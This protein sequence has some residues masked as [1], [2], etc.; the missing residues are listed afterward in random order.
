MDK[1]Y[2]D[3]FQLSLEKEKFL[4][5]DCFF[6]FDSSALLCFYSLSET[7]RQKIYNEIFTLFKGR[8][9]LPAHVQFEFFKNRETV[10]KKSIPEHYNPIEDSL[11]SIMSDIKNADKKLEELLKKIKNQNYHPF[12]EQTNLE[13][14]RKYL[15]KVP[16]F[17]KKVKTQIEERK[18]EILQLEK[19]DSVLENLSVYFEVGKE[20]SFK[21]IIEIC[22]E[23]DHRY[24]YKIP[25][26]FKDLT[27]KDKEGI[28]IF[29]DL[30][31]WKQIL[32]F[33]STKKTNIVFVCNDFTTDW[34]ITEPDNK[35]R[36]NHPKE[37]LILEFTETTGKNFWMYSL[38]QF[39]YTCNR[40]LEIKTP[41]EI[42]EKVIDQITE[43][44]LITKELVIIEAKYFTPNNSFDSKYKLQ[45]L[46]VNN[47]LDTVA[48][49]S[50]VGDP[51]INSYKKLQIKY[52]Y[53]N[54]IFEKIYNEHDQIHIP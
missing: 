42:K 1:N 19:H 53:G 36:I 15:D 34:C 11:K 22:R 40:L 21:E 45:S 51:E 8:L 31:I 18:N 27:E 41:I 20:Y 23:G 43:D 38:D 3:K 13:S 52:S 49:N 46:I 35:K 17:E 25:P 4:W 33:A 54:E 12:I 6:V 29:G 24:D 32:E 39:I 7:A 50:L 30:I 44:K 10:I 2:F 5:A 48:D 16:D 14:L 26:G 47:K 9:W 28:Q 37:E